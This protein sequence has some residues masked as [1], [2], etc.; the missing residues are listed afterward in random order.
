MFPCSFLILPIWIFS[1]IFLVCL[2]SLLILLPFSR[3]FL[4]SCIS[5]VVFHSLVHFLFVFLGISSS[6][7]VFESLSLL[8]HI[9]E[10]NTAFIIISR[11]RSPLLSNFPTSVSWGFPE[12][13]WHESHRLRAAEMRISSLLI[14][15]D[16][17]RI[18]KNSAILFSFCV[19]VFCCFFLAV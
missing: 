11:H 16:I 10:V 4:I 18:C 19:L 17:K 8:Q 6:Q 15:S 3:N 1:L 9:L 13:P 2:K 7:N 12:I 14:K 5:S